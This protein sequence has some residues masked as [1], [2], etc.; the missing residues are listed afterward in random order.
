MR[1]LVV[2]LTLLFVLSSLA[3]SKNKG[4]GDVLKSFS[5]GAAVVAIAAGASGF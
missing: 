2:L 3:G 4:V 5:G 1:N